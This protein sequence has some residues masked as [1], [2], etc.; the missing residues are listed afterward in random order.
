M[1][2]LSTLERLHLGSSSRRLWHSIAETYCW[3]S[4]QTAFTYGLASSTPYVTNASRFT[5][6][7]NTWFDGF[8]KLQFVCLVDMFGH[9]YSWLS[10]SWSS[11]RTPAGNPS[12]R[13]NLHSCPLTY[14]RANP[15]R[16]PL[17]ADTFAGWTSHLNPSSRHELRIH[18]LTTILG[19]VAVSCRALL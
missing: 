7:P 16:I 18:E 4:F 8:H 2:D 9:P 13:A 3:I 15:R 12:V 1:A 10:H 11:R 19:Y 5:R 17:T 6:F 14:L